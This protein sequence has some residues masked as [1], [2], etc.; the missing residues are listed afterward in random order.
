MRQGTLSAWRGLESVRRHFVLAEDYIA[1]FVDNQPAKS[2]FICDMHILGHVLKMTVSLWRAGGLGLPFTLMAS[3]RDKSLLVSMLQKAVCR[4]NS[5]VAA[6]SALELS[7]LAPLD[8][9]RRLTIVA[10]IVSADANLF[11]I[12][13]LMLMLAWSKPSDVV[14]ESDI[15]F[16]V[17][18]AEALAV[19]PVYTVVDCHRPNSSHKVLRD[20][21]QLRHDDVA[22]ALI[23]RS[24]FG[25]MPGDMRML[26]RAAETHH[27][28]APA[29][30]SFR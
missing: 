12:V 13:W 23:L 16:M 5:E 8:L 11:T 21:A 19:N 14:L 15:C 28:N 7:H 2:R 24:A 27:A 9:A 10:I 22:L 6:S 29:D 20:K 17:K 1:S 18:Y 4:G 3:V 26:L 25:G 30:C